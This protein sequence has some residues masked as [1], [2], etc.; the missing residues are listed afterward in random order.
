M[1][2][3]PALPDPSILTLED[4]VI[5]LG[6]FATVGLYKRGN[7]PVGAKVISKHKAV[8]AKVD[9]RLLLERQILAALAGNVACIPKITAVGPSGKGTKD[10]AK[11]ENVDWKARKDGADAVVAKML[12][13]KS[14]AKKMKHSS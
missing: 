6:S 2:A 3:L 10:K 11:I 7:V 8:E 5:A 9:A 12:K 14:M 1:L 13:K 4:H